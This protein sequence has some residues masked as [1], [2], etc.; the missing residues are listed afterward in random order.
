MNDNPEKLSW[1]VRTACRAVRCNPQILALAPIQDHYTVVSEAALLLLVAAITGVA[2]TAF[3]A[4]FLPLPIAC[5]FGV[6][7]LAFVFLINSTI[8]AAD[9]R[10][11]GVLRQPGVRQGREYWIRLSARFG[12]TAI[13]SGATSTGAAMAMFHNAIV[14]QLEHDQRELNQKIAQ[15]YDA[16][17]QALRTR[18]IGTQ[19]D[20]VEA[21]QKSVTEMTRIVDTARQARVTASKQAET[22]TIEADRELHGAPGYKAGAGTKYREA[23]ARK[24]AADAALAK[25]DEDVKIYEPRLADAQQKLDAAKTE[26][27][28]AETGFVAEAR[29]LDEEKKAHLVPMR[30]DALMAYMALQE[31]YRSP[32]YGSAALRF[33]WLMVAVL[34]TIELS[35]VIVRVWFTHASVYMALLIADTKLRAERAAAHLARESETLRADLRRPNDRVPLQIV[36]NDPLQD[37]KKE[38]PPDAAD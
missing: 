38:P 23:L 11:T 3:W 36:A 32:V 8:G 1:T 4:Q 2:W 12:M 35:Y 21:L 27:K 17:L 16:Q 10:L 15:Q 9:W 13:L 22:Q 20:N 14:T 37:I 33:T 19:L 6:L 30:N 18:L 26:L 25:A 34:M 24:E 7:A 31:I 5:V 29:K 28:T